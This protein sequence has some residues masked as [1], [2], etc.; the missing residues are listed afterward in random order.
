MTN[1]KHLRG[2][3]KT[4]QQRKIIVCNSITYEFSYFYKAETIT[5]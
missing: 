2:N 4:V 3:W 5:V 1:T